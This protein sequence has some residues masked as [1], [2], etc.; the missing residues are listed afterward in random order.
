M[1]V[2]CECSSGLGTA[3]HILMVAVS[4]SESFRR[5]VICIISIAFFVASSISGGGLM[6]EKIQLQE[7]ASS[8]KVGQDEESGIWV[9]GGQPWPQFGRTASRIGEV[10]GHSPDGGAGDGSPTNATSLKSIVKP[11][12]NWVYGSYSIGTDSLSTPIADLGNSIE[13][14]PGAIERCG[15]SS[16]FTVIVQTEDVSGSSHSILRLIEGE[17]SELAW[18]ADLGETEA[19][20]A[21]PVIVDIDEDSRPEIVVVYDSGGSMYVEAWSPRLS[22]TVTAR[23]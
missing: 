6:G 15:G 18:Q 7:G 2:W 13:V 14:G 10:A 22:C 21:S 17:D 3:C 8:K 16:L 5:K 12:V 20:K 11:A 23:T 4:S 1:R 19:I 9:D